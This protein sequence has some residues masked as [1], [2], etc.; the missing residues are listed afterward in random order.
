MGAFGRVGISHGGS[1]A[2]THI[3]NSKGTV[4][5]VPSQDPAL[6]AKN[7]SG[8]SAR[9][10]PTKKLMQGRSQPSILLPPDNFT[11]NLDGS[12]RQP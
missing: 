8:F 12:E 4:K 11:T 3:D 5:L 10:N 2:V 7:N 6:S 9:A 1:Q